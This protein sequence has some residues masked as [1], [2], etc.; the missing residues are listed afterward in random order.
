MQMTHRQPQRELN[1]H[2][3]LNYFYGGLSSEFPLMNH[4]A[5]PGSESV[6]GISQ[7]PPM[8]AFTSLSKDGFQQR[9]LWVCWHHL[10][11]G[12]AHSLFDFQGAV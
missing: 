2:G 4:L 7:D 11:R 3:G 1:P 10:L 6:F 5:L 8:S 9:G 12:G